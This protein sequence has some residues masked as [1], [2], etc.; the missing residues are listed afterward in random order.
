[1]RWVSHEE[2]GKEL[3][4]NPRNGPQSCHRIAC[5]LSLSQHPDPK[6]WLRKDWLCLAWGTFVVSNIVMLQPVIRWIFW[7]EDVC[8]MRVRAA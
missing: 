6:R 3:L 2:M 8:E 4:A 1:M 7:K 5:L